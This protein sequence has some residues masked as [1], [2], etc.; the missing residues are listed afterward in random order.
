MTQVTKQA[1]LDVARILQDAGW[2][3]EVHEPSAQGTEEQKTAQ[4]TEQARGQ[5][6]DRVLGLA[7]ETGL[8]PSSAEPHQALKDVAKILHE[9]G[10]QK[11][12]AAPVPQQA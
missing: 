1:L 4:F 12:E 9:A 8:V 11:G 7:K 3:Q 5:F 6:V 2:D 10:W